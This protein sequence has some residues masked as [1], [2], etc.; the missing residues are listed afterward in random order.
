MFVILTIATGRAC[1]KGAS[2]GRDARLNV[3]TW[4]AGRFW[5]GR[6]S[7]ALVGH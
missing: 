2:Y 6:D 4:R 3:A 7:Y 1:M 5:N